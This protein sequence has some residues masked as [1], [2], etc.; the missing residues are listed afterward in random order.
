MSLKPNVKKD[1]LLRFHE[2]LYEPGW[3]FKGI[4]PNEKDRALLVEF[5]VVRG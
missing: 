2:K 3:C 5:H 1:L 4:G